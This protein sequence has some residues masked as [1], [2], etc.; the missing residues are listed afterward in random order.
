M[1]R[2][3]KLMKGVRRLTGAI[4]TTTN[5][6]WDDVL[7]VMP[8]KLI[9]KILGE[10]TY[11][12]MHTW[13][14]QICTDLITVETP[15]D[16]GRGKGHLGMLQA[17]AVFHARNGDFYNPPPNAPTAYPNTLP[18]A[19]TAKRERLRAKHKVLYVHWAKYVHTGRIKVSIWAAAFDE[20]VLVALKEPNEGLNGFT[21][22]GVYDYFM[23]NYVT[24]SQ[25]DVDANLDTF[26]EPIDASHTLAVYIRKQELCQEM[27]EYAHVPITK[28]TIVT[29]DTKHSVATSGMDDACSVWMRLPNNQHTWV[30]WKKTLNGDFLEKRELVRLTGI[31]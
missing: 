3:P 16:C 29:T 18:R 26:N 13:F 9:N 19:N 17:P 8:H 14:N 23:G 10:P 7:V 30:R 12:A 5:V 31:A 28:A 11:S 1:T 24:I 4:M 2:T 15:Q 20:W 21:I 22:H 27:A 25:A 6:S